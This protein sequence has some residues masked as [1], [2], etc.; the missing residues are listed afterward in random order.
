MSKNKRIFVSNPV[1]PRRPPAPQVVPVV[2]RVV[3]REHTA[4]K[5]LT[6]AKGKGG[7]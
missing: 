6:G 3:E 5:A 2:R 1:G 7:G 4:K